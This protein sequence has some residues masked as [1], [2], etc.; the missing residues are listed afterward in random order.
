[1]R[2]SSAPSVGLQRTP[3][4]AGVLM[5]L[6][7]GRLYRGAWTDWINEWAE[8]NCTRF[9]KAKCQVLCLGHSH[10]VQHY[11]L[12]KEWLESCPEENDLGVSVGS[13]LNK[14]QQCAQVA[15]KANGIV[16]CTET[17]WPVR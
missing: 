15:E 12:G 17:V 1:M 16:A 2:G 4:W 5:C 9:D 11:R 3:S 7:V 14:N 13:W 8:A 10:P 6:R